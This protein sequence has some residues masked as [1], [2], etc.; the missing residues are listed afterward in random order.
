MGLCVGRNTPSGAGQ[1]SRNSFSTK[2]GTSTY[3]PPPWTVTVGQQQEAATANACILRST[4]NNENT[5]PHRSPLH[6][7][8]STVHNCVDTIVLYSAMHDDDG[9]DVCDQSTVQYCIICA[10]SVSTLL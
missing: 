2:Q 3:P 9:D 1:Q 7:Q 4:N 8:Y 5:N 6:T 10:G